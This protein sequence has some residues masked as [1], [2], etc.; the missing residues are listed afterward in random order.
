MRVRTEMDPTKLTSCNLAGPLACS[1]SVLVSV[2]GMAVCVD[3]DHVR[4][5]CSSIFLSALQS[6]LSFARSFC[7]VL[8]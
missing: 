1:V 4:E 2:C 3:D 7:F 5:C 6:P 8:L